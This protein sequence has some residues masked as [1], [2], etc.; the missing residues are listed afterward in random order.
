DPATPLEQD[1]GQVAV[2]VEQAKEASRLTAGHHP[3]RDGEPGSVLGRAGCPQRHRTALAATESAYGVPLAL[4]LEEGV[5]GVDGHRGTV[6][7][8][9][10]PQSPVETSASP[11]S[12]A[13]RPLM[14]ELTPSRPSASASA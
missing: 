2:R 5:G 11:P 7:S 9:S 4:G 10:V 12:S 13:T 3:R 6:I 8:H 14:D 1:L